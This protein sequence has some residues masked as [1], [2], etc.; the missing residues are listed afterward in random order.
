MS[1][2]REPRQEF[3]LDIA[4]G[5]VPGHSHI[6]KFGAAYGFAAAATPVD[7]W[8]GW[9][10]S[11]LYQFSSTADIDTVSSSSALDT[12]LIEVQGLDTNWALVTQSA[13]LNGQNK[14][15]LTTPLLRVFRMLNASG[16]AFV[17]DIYCYVDGAITAGVPDDLTTVRAVAEAGRDQ[18]LMAIYSVPANTR[19]YLDR[20]GV[21][22]FSINT[23]NSG[24]YELRV[25]DFGGVFRVQDTFCANTM[26]VFNRQYREPIVLPEKSD[27]L[28][29][30]SSL[31]NTSADVHAAFSVILVED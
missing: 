5:R 13:T 15:V 27:V 19:G 14:V 8:S 21:T 17:G 28:V 3:Y 26:A 29:R 6:N 12:Q 10:G 23:N 18:T 4:K 25:R 11:A 20:V 9:A 1:I 16:T 30:C 22:A 2:E 7:I 24:D 31:K